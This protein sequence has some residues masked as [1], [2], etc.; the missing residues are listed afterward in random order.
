MNNKL[1]SFLLIAVFYSAVLVGRGNAQDFLRTDGQKIVD[2]YGQEIHFRGMGIGGWLEMEGYM[3]LTSS[4]ANSPS[5]IHD[6]IQNLIG[7]DSTQKFYDTFRKDF[8]TEADIK[9]LHDWGFNLIRVPFHYNVLTPPDSPGVYLESGF[10]LFDS[11]ISWCSKYDIYVILDMHCAPGSQNSDNIGD[12]NSSVP[13]LWQDTTAQT[14]TV[15][16]W[17]KI[18]ERYADN[19][20]VAGYDLLNEPHWN[21]GADNAPLRA[22]YVRITSAIRSVDTNH[23]V[24]IEGNNYATDFNGL[25]PPWDDNMAYSFHKYWNT[26]NAASIQGYLDL[27]ANN[28]VPLWLGE[29]GENSNPWYSECI[30]LMDQ[31]DIGWSWWT[32]KKFNTITSP[33]SVPITGNYQKLLDYWEGK[34]S[35]PSVAFA[36]ATLLDMAKRLKFGN[37][38]YLKDVI[39]A[40][41]RQP[42]NYTTLPF[43]NDTI[44]GVVYA[45]NYDLGRVGYAYYDQDYENTGGSNTVWNQGGCYRNDGVDIEACSDPTSNGYDV[46]W[47]DDGEWMQYTVNVTKTGNYNIGIIYASTQAGGQ[48]I[49]RLDGDVLTPSGVDVPTSGGWQNWKELIVP[50]VPLT[51]GSHVFKIQ[52]MTGGFNLASFSFAASPTG[53]TYSPNVVYAFELGQNFPNPFNPSTVIEFQVPHSSFVTLRI[54]DILGREVATLVNGKINAGAYKAVWNGAEYPSGVYFY[55]LQADGFAQVKRMLLLK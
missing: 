42:N 27:R 35:K 33:L 36:T 50:D 13:S 18:A 29:S 23:I 30:S 5:E 37:C 49:L 8:V 22:L 12:Y 55:R 7:A 25:T 15:A 4:F 53:V 44:P 17:K 20:T 1:T 31:Y 28:N 16:I 40:M 34:A 54:Y 48:F 10:A 19:P 21:L 43:V 6:A 32:L 47:I 45:D 38:V 3:F 26:N 52:V 11:L 24:F 9:A 51:A 46:G 41:M 2:R 39:D 14:R